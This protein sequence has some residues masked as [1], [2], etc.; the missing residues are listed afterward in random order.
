MC[1]VEPSM[2]QVEPGGS[3]AYAWDTKGGLQLQQLERQKFR[4]I[5]RINKKLR[6]QKHKY[7]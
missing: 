2:G 3:D 7:K 6:I 4:C 1:Q 5:C